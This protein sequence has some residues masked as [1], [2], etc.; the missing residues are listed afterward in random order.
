VFFLC[1]APIAGLFGAATASRKIFFGQ[2]APAAV[3]LGLVAFL[4]EA[5]FATDWSGQVRHGTLRREDK[6]LGR[7]L[8]N[9]VHW[10]AC[11]KLLWRRIGARPSNGPLPPRELGD[12]IGSNGLTEEI[13]LHVVAGHVL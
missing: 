2:A 4:L 6:R 3:G 10:F 9:A 12:L 8:A 1:C 5:D 7:Q 13:A 11:K